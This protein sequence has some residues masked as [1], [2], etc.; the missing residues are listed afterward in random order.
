MAEARERARQAQEEFAA[1][2]AQIAGLDEG[3]VDLDSDHETASLALATAEEKIAAL[4][5]DERAAEQE[6]AALVARKDALE[7]GLARKDGSGALLAATD[8]V[9]GLLGSVAA[10]LTVEQGSEAAVAAALGAAADAVAVS[11]VG[12]AVDALR[13]LKQDDSG[14]T[15]LLVGGGSTTGSTG[16]PTLPAHASYAVD[17]VSAPEQL[18]PA[19][20]ALLDRVAVVDGLAEARALIEAEPSLTAATRD[21]DLLG[22]DVRARRLG[23]VA[24][25]ARGS[26]SGRRRE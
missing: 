15:G 13:W 8:Q 4:R 19:L 21:G 6:R 16:W 12:S 14:R 3:E 1:L 7:L 11:S 5:E 22:P 10:L 17:L 24:Q 26:G 2:E 18:R 9:S 20:H 23:V 25:F